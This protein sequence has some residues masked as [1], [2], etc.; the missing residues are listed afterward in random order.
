ML[1]TQL[2]PSK[3]SSKLD[4]TRR[5]SNRVA[6]YVKARPSYPPDLLDFLEND[7]IL[8]PG[9]PVADIGS[10]TGIFSGLLLERGYPV[11]CV[12]PNAEMRT[13]AEEAFHANP[14]FTSVDGTAEHTTLDDDAVHAITS[15]QAFHWF[16][17]EQSKQ[18]FRRIM[19]PGGAAVLVWNDRDTE[20]T[21]FAR[22]YDALI[23]AYAIDLSAIRQARLDL[24]RIQRLFE[25]Q[26]CEIK[27]F[28][29]SQRLDFDGLKAR[30]LSSSY[31]PREGT[32]RY[33]SMLAELRRLFSDTQSEGFVTFEYTTS[34]YWG[35]LCELRYSKIMKIE[36]KASLHPGDTRRG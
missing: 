12:E 16:D 31:M 22:R 2:M 5:F 33:P 29:N 4:P 34:L 27:Q 18:E 8:T 32:P 35:F 28:Y 36:D 1:V 17:V 30:M 24:V 6:D 25:P 11:F 26:S 15:A 9:K 7:E 20:S 23:H 10:G 14:L 19:H 3:K 13:A 21:T